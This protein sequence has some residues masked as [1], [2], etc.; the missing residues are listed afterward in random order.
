[1]CH[2]D[3]PAA[4]PEGIVEELK[5]RQDENGLIGFQR[6]ARFNPGDTVRVVEGVFADCLGLYEGI[7]DR[8]RAAILLDL[9]GRKVRVA[10]PS[11]LLDTA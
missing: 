6:R 8:E 7:D 4:V 9:L 10:L 1:V 5:R 3:D 11:D 2:G